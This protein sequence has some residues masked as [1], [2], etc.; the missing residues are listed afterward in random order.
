[1]EHLA[2]K[3]NIVSKDIEQY[4]EIF[5]LCIAPFVGSSNKFVL[6]LLRNNQIIDRCTLFMCVP[7]IR[8]NPLMGK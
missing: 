8:Y 6:L 4:Y 2:V 5:E 1:M 7:F 3:C